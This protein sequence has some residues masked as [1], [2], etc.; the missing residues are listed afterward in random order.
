MGLADLLQPAYRFEV[1]LGG[2]TTAARACG[3]GGATRLCVQWALYLVMPRGAGC[4]SSTRET[5]SW[6]WPIPTP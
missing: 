2:V 1:H 3:T 5:W 4:S 6:T